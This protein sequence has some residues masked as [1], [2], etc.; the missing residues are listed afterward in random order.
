MSSLSLPILL[1]IVASSAAPVRPH[2]VT[3]AGPQLRQVVQRST[4][5]LQK[6]GA[7]WMKKQQCASCHHIPVM[8]WALN[9]ARNQ[10]YQVNDKLLSE[11]TSWANAAPSSRTARG[12]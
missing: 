5:Y 6:Q 2:E 9:E 11:V 8:V 4:E 3:T 1:M 7:T 12:P 10:G